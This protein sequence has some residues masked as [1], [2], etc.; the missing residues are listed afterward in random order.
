MCDST[1]GFVFIWPLL[2]LLAA[3]AIIFLATEVLL[4]RG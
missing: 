3:L 4:R 1:S 2:A